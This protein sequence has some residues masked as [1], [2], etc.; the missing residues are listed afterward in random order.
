MRAGLVG[1]PY[2]G[3]TTLFEAVAGPSRSGAIAS[4][5]V[6]DPRLDLICQAVSPKKRTPAHLEMVDDAAVMPT[7]GSG[8]AADFAASARRVDV[9]VHVV[10]EFESETV[11]YHSQPDP[12]RD[13][14]SLVS[15]LLFADLHLVENRL[16]RLAKSQ[17]A[18][19]SGTQEYL[20]K[21]L[22]E[23]LKASLE[24]GSEVRRCELTEQEGDLLLNYQL[25]TAKPLVVA[26][27]CE[28]SQLRQLTPFEDSVA[29]SGDPVFRVCCALEKELAALEDEDRSAF[30][31]DLGIETAA[32]GSLIRAVYQALGLITFF[33]AGQNE[34]KAW[35]LKDGSTALKAAATVHTDIAKGFIRA[36]V[37]GYED[38]ERLGSV[39][40]CYDQG[41]MRLEGKE[42]RVRDGD[43]INIRNKS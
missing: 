27:N 14:G 21:A 28:E 40:A 11:P 24:N 37:V 35:P 16:E 36:E 4:V 26:V 38:F 43:I 5:P 30:L 6:P 2:A 9:L 3:K 19:K 33:T 39:K 41:L 32:S 15:E 17:E 29:S 1:F 25:L 20:E 18:K 13:H 22:F 42:Y 31:Q 12:K 8:R 34:T 10:R 23:R 7:P